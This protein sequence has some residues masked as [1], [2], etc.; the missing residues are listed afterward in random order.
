MINAFPEK[1]VTKKDRI[2]A[3]R[4]VCITLLHVALQFVHIFREAM[5]FPGL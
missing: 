3:V 2:L 4:T 5:D 1:K